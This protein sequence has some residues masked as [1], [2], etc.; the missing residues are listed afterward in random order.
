MMTM[1]ERARTLSGSTKH[2]VLYQIRFIFRNQIPEHRRPV[3]MNALRVA[4]NKGMPFRQWLAR[5][6]KAITAGMGQPVEILNILRRDFGAERHVFEAVRIVAA[7]VG[8]K[9]QVTAGNIGQANLARVFILK[10]YLTAQAASVA[11]GLPFGF[12]HLVDEFIKKFRL[13]F[14]HESSIRQRDMDEKP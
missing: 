2:S 13:S 11:N 1:L 6:H 9:T 3:G 14:A 10:P 7:P 5:R 12:G 8:I 4:A